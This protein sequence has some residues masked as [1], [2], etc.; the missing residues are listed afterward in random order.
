MRNEVLAKFVCHNLCCLI[1]AQHE[2]GI[3]PALAE[4]VAEDE[5]M[6]LPLVR[7]S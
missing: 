5:R 1:M 2:L 3:I 6:V 7:P 4:E